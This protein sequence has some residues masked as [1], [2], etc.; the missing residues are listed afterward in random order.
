[1]VWLDGWAA[2]VETVE[3]GSMAAAARR[4]DCSRA[5]V[6][7]KLGELEQAFGVRLLER[8]TRKLSLTP[9]GEVFYQHALRVL[10]GI[11]D[12]E[13]ALQNM[14][15][16][17]RGILRIS[18]SVAFGRLHVAPLLPLLAQEYPQLQCELILNDRITDLVEERF[19]LALRLSDALP[20]NVV[21]RK[22]GYVK[23]VLCAS[24]DYLAA[25]GVPAVP[26]D[27]V[28][29]HCFA[30]SHGRTESDWRLAGPSGEVTIP[31][32]GKFQINDVASILEAVLQDHG[33][34]ILPTYLCGPE[35][36]RGRLRTLLDD[37]EPVTTF[38]RYVYACYP[39]SRVQLPK[40]RVV[41]DA[42]E[43]HF[44]P[45]PPWERA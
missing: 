24:P 13:L 16:T 43:R 15:D 6:S 17:P 29:H 32:R 5:Q 9:G 38:G 12:A 1:M 42:L 7:K 41:L 8:T 23:R 39:P 20:E 30:Y 35:L 4:L 27:L 26:Q 44:S 21:A 22:L 28:H 11:K 36:A 40:L 18:A 14:V 37:H 3:A 45:L 33:I 19:D 2:F 31:V 10:A 34:A 25:M